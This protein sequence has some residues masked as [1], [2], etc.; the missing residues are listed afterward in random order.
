VFITW[1]PNDFD[2]QVSRFL[3]ESPKD[4]E[5]RNGSY[6]GIN[7][8]IGEVFFAQKKSFWSTFFTRV[9][10]LRKIVGQRAHRTKNHSQLIMR[11]DEL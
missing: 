8:N 4:D 5:Q 6:S 9:S 10:I 3:A 7:S 11:A 2:R 1:L